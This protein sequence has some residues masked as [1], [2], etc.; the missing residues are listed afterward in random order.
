MCGSAWPSTGAQQLGAVGSTGVA[1]GPH[2]HFEV[3]RRDVPVDPVV[4]LRERLTPELAHA[5][6]RAFLQAVNTARIQFEE[7]SRDRRVALGVNRDEIAG[8]EP[9]VSHIVTI[10]FR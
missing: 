6:H 7:A 5:Y 3:R 1:T 8:R 10:P 4:P 2:L 9:S